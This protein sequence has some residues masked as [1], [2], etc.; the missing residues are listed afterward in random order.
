MGEDQKS[1]EIEAFVKYLN[2]SY[3]PLKSTDFERKQCFFFLDISIFPSIQLVDNR[4]TLPQTTLPRIQIH[5]YF[6]FVLTL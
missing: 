3:T 2:W 4:H 1:L 5:S 6:T